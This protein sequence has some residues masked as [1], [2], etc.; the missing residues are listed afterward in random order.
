MAGSSNGSAKRIIILF[1]LAMIVVGGFAMLVNRNKST[2]VTPTQI[3]EVEDALARNLNTNYPETPKELLKYYSQI[4]KCFYSMDYTEEQLDELA[5]KSRELLD[6]DLKAQQTDEEYLRDL[7]TSIDIFKS[8]DR[9]ISSYSVSSAA[10]IEYNKYE[11][12]DWAKAYCIFTVRDGKKMVVTQEEFLLR[13]SMD[14]HW[15]IF[16]WRIVED[17]EETDNG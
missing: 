5:V 6:E 3:T 10:D 4:T 2:D 7:K 1:M 14:G 15:K 12:S 16:G 8:L 9:T 17:D 11:G 13:K